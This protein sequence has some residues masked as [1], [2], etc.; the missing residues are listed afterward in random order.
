MR[1]PLSGV[2]DAP[3]PVSIQFPRPNGLQERVG[4]G[5]PIQDVNQPPTSTGLLWSHSSTRS[6]LAGGGPV[7][8]RKLSAVVVVSAVVQAAPAQVSRASPT[9]DAIPRVYLIFV[10]GSIGS[11]L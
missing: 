6:N 2:L 3:G 9:V 1:D 5:Q 4:S 8:L 7:M 10:P 11:I